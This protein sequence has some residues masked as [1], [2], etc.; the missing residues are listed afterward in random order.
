MSS[1]LGLADFDPPFVNTVEE[2]EPYCAAIRPYVVGYPIDRISAAYNLYYDDWN[3][4]LPILI[5]VNGHCI[6]I[7]NFKFDE[8]TLGI[9][10]LSP[11]TEIEKDWEQWDFEWREYR[12]EGVLGSVIEDVRP[13]IEENPRF[14]NYGLLFGVEFTLSTGVLRVANGLDTNM[15]IVCD[16]DGS[17]EK[18]YREG[19]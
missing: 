5:E 18:I 17:N 6:D 15:F 13:C 4:D 9:D 2:L 12:V 8:V 11:K 10:R 14:M 19:L 1:W 3:T 7:M 16:A